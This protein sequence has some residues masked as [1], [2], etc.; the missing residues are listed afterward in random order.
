MIYI[1]PLNAY[2][3]S[4][5]QPARLSVNGRPACG[6]PLPERHIESGWLMA[7]DLCEACEKRREYRQMGLFAE[8]E[9]WI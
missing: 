5:G 8:V 6:A 7:W 3:A 1:L 4:G 9:L 2:N